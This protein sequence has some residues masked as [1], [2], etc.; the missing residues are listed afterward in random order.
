MESLIKDNELIETINDLVRQSGR[1]HSSG[2]Q[3]KQESAVAATDN[4]DQTDIDSGGKGK[5]TTQFNG[6]F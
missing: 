4:N 2:M 5:E 1:L 6:V 3:V